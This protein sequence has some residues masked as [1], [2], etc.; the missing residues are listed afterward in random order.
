MS[1]ASMNISIAA[2]EAGV[3]AKMI[4]HYEEIG[5]LAHVSRSANGYRTY[6]TQDV[7]VLRFIRSARN[8]GFSMSQISDLLGLWRDQGR[9]SRKVKALALAHIADLDERIRQLNS[10]K[11]VLSRLAN[12]C[13][14]DERSEC[15]ILEG[16]AQHL[17]MPD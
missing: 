5:L 15:A 6:S 7:Q 11:D 17:E 4:R 9:S 8:L 14:G 1:N 16:L 3:S 2:Q 10:M 13:H 12:S